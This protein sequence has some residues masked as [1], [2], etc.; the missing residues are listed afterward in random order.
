MRN[1]SR[2]FT[3]A[4]L[5]VAAG[6]GGNS[7]P[8]PPPAL[9]VTASIDNGAVPGVTNGVKA[10]G[11]NSVTISVSG[12]TKAPIKLVAHKGAFEGGAQ[13][14][15][16]NDVSGQATLFTCDSR[17][18]NSCAGGTTVS[19]T[20]ANFAFGSAT[21]TMVGFETNCT[22]N[23]DDN[24]DGR[25]DCADP[26]CDNQAC[27]QRTGGTGTCTAG[28][29]VPPV[30][31]PTSTTEVC[32]N[33][34]DDDCDG[35][36]DCEQDS[37]DGMPCMQGMPTFV[38]KA[39][40]C[41]DVGTGYAITIAAKR[42]RLPAD[43]LATTTVTA[44]V[45]KKSTPQ[46]GV[47]VDFTTTAGA[48]AT[49]TDPNATM[50][51]AFTGADGTVTVPFRASLE[52]AKATVTVSLHD[53]PPVA[54][55]TTITM[56]AL[57]TIVIGKILNPVMGVKYSG[58]NEQNV[59]T[60]SLI[61][62]EQKPYPDGLAVRFEHQQLAGSTITQPYTPDT[63][64]CLKSVGCY[65]HISQ[66]MS[67]G[68]PDTGGIAAIDLYSGTA[69][70]PLSVLVTANAGGISRSFTIQNI[71]VVGA[72]ANGA[73]IT[74]ACTPQNVPGLV[75][76]DCLSAKGGGPV[77]CTVYLGDRFNNVLG[78]AT[79][80]QFLSEAGEFGPPVTTTA[81]DPQRGGDQT[82]MIGHASNT[83]T[84]IGKGLPID[85]DPLAGEFNRAYDSGCG[86]RTH[87]P[88]DGLNTIMVAVQGEEGFVDL[89]G[90]GVYDDGEP[91]IDSA[92]PFVDMNDNNVW[93]EGEPFIDVNQN[94]KWDGPNGKWDADTVIWAETRV[95]YTGEA[96]VPDSRWLNATDEIL[97]PGPTTTPT[98]HVSSVA[99]PPTSQAF[100]IYTSDANFNALATSATFD[101]KALAGNVTPMITSSPRTV[102]SLGMSFQQQ[103]CNAPPPTT[104]V[105]AQT[106][107]SVPCYRW[108]KVSGFK[109][110]N[111]G[112]VS[113]TGAKTGPDTVKCTAV[114]GG[115]S[116]LFSISGISD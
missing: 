54:Q 28:A 39:R 64:T 97:L 3:V 84:V 110:G 15:I 53:L 99:M 19:A 93:D 25:T 49:E 14:F 21:I 57:G 34:I 48:F 65:G 111:R 5:V 52:A 26:D 38:C 101:V 2:P 90:N 72:K 74:V 16:I 47:A 105:C 68:M 58:F 88:R 46:A 9:T 69:A 50:V 81:Y 113:I 27:K 98:F 66:T 92:E 89:N 109:Y 13:T 6:C 73:H 51:T 44:K 42:S 71:F 116:T 77:T 60:V 114:V 24:K 83:V 7:T 106:C 79:R 59:V 108:T 86:T 82:A 40:A 30:C 45:V 20:D 67:P 107:T 41:T 43:G 85:V 61:D 91:F 112:T 12:G 56:P 87:N 29:C 102:D 55:M 33:Q 37:C 63:A 22:N 31:T 36:T 70:G 11:A 18:D 10:D 62:T 76:N 115:I 100:A 75:D 96:V 8:P 94:Q 95:L 78:V 17:T 1:P 35:K 80:A 4:A 32:N 104:A 23:L 103:Y